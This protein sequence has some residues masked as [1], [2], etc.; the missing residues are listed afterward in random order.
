MAYEIFKEVFDHSL[1]YPDVESEKL[2]D[3]SEKD[4][5]VFHKLVQNLDDKYRKKELKVVFRGEKKKLLEKNLFEHGSS[6]INLSKLLGR[7]FYFGGKA[8]HYFT[9]EKPSDCLKNIND[10]SDKTYEFIFNE[11]KKIINC[12]FSS[13]GIRKSIEAFKKENQIFSDFFSCSS[14]SDFCDL[15]GGHSDRGRIRD[16]YLYFLHTFGNQNFK[17]LSYFVSTSEDWETA[18]KFAKSTKDDSKADEQE[19]IV[20]VYIVPEPL[21]KHG[22]NLQEIKDFNLEYKDSG[23]PIYGTDL[24]PS[25]Q[26]VSVKGAL[27]PQFLL[28]VYYLKQK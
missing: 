21:Y 17:K 25:Q 1:R 16:Y 5:E 4:S 9:Q 19:A 10:D 8:K 11:I 3:L 18:F 28:G 15:V 7:L 23:L 13:E 26:E 22:I 6:D 24:Y 27:F 12:D 2:V 14:A 20:F